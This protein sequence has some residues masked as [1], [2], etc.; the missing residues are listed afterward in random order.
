[1]KYMGS[2]NRHSRELLKI[3]LKD[4]KEGQWYVEP[5]AG[6]CNMIDKVT[7]NRVANDSHPY[8]ISMWR[9]LVNNG[10][11]PPQSVSEIDYQVAAFAVREGV[12]IVGF[13]DYLIGY[14]GFNSYGGKW[15]GGYRRDGQGKRDYWMEHWKNITRQVPNLQGVVF[16]NVSYDKLVLPDNSLIYC[17]PPY[18]ST[19]NYADGF[20]TDCFWRWVREQI[21]NGHTVFVSEYTAP[22]D[23]V[24]VW[25]KE[26]N[27]TLVRNTGSKK[28]VEK[29]FVYKG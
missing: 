24:S 10:W 6:G 7:G 18:S 27:N 15:L 1:M 25:D 2:K 16:S 28:G 13:P 17:D 12:D 5:F 4:R 22:D 20:D 19:T 21:H 8:L 26:V 3:I 29:L 9:A 11:A 14:I 23:F